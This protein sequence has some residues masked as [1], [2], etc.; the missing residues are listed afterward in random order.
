MP[1]PPAAPWTSSRSPTVSP[2]CVKSAS[3]AVVNDLGD[4]AGRGPVELLGHRHRGALVHDR[5]LGL[6]AAADDGHDAVATS[7]RRRRRR[8]DDLAG[9]LQARDVRRRARR[10]RVAAR[11]LEHV[12]AVEPGRAHAHEQLARLG[13]GSGCSSTTISPSRMVA[14]RIG[15]CLHTCR[16]RAGDSAGDRPLR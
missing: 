6:A 13:A 2:A 10:R 11:E 15:R 5:E 14:A 12:G 1:T 8:R 16:V 3:W 9:Q 7:K 4:A